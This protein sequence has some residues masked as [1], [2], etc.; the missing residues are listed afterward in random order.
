MAQEDYENFYAGLSGIELPVPKY[1]F[2][3]EYQNASRLTYYSTFFNSIEINSSFYKIPMKA[4]VLRWTSSVPANFRFTFKLFREITHV[5]ELAFNVSH[6]AHFVEIISHV[7][8]KKGCLL[9]QFPPSLQRESSGQLAELLTGIRQADPEGMWPV[10]VE[11]RNRGWYIPEVYDLLES[12]KASLVIH[13]IPRSATPLNSV[14]SDVIYA[15]FH[16]PTGNYRGSYTDAFLQEYAE[17]IH[18]W[19]SDGKTV[20]AYFNNTAGDAFNNLRTLKNLLAL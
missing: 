6:I 9:V 8:E 12:H 18:E 15:R 20:Y 14:S 5:K 11:F 4:T 2:P 7:A 3:P 17:Y 13:D 16:G 1:Q 19:L 10:A